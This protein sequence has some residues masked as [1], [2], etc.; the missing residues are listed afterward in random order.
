V[1]IFSE[2]FQW[3]AKTDEGADNCFLHRRIKEPSPMRVRESDGCVQRNWVA[4]FS[5]SASL[6]VSLAIWRG[7]F[8]AV[9]RLVK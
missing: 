5:Y 4:I 1:V 6:V 3:F 8:L 7:V 2:S 9:G